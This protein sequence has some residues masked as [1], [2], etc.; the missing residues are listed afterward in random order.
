MSDQIPD[1]FYKPINSEPYIGEPAIIDGDLVKSGGDYRR[2]YGIDNM[3]IILIGTDSGWWGNLV[4]PPESQIPGGQDLT[5]EAI[6][7]D[8][9]KKHAANQERKLSPLITTNITESVKVESFN[10]ENDRI[11]WIAEIKMTDGRK[12]FYD[13]LEGGHYE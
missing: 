11:D 3:I 6:T 1:G 13:S 2:N 4:L 10:T 5:S 7:S 12:Y 9:L 8:F